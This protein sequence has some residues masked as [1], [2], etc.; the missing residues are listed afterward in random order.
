MRGVIMSF[1]DEHFAIVM[2]SDLHFTKIARQSQMH[3]GDELDVGDQQV[4]TVLSRQR[5]HAWNWQRI[6][7]TSV[8]VM[9]VVFVF[10]YFLVGKVQPVDAMPYAYVSIDINPS[11]SFTVNAKDRVLAVHALDHDAKTAIVGLRLVNHS[12]SFA[13]HRYLFALKHK[14]MFTSKSSV[15]ITTSS[16]TKNEQVI[17]AN[18]AS[19]QILT[20]KVKNEVM[21]SLPQKKQAILSLIVHPSVMQAATHYDLSAGRLALY[22]EA[23]RLGQSVTWPLLVSGHMAQAVGGTT[24]LDKII[25]VM[26]KDTTLANVLQAIAK[27]TVQSTTKSPTT[28]T[29]Q[30]DVILPPPPPPLPPSLSSNDNHKSTGVIMPPPAPPAL[31]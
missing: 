12:L 21:A 28:S 19:L 15:I 6:G 18:H 13:L 3:I 4:Q 30:S 5:R 7:V 23:K 11:I 14:G 27:K 16:A 17:D 9:A 22:E 24:K 26:A 2:T 25:V 8:A 1:Q 29:Y 10:A 20:Q 31:P